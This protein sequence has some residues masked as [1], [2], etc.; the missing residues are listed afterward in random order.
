MI[1]T[2]TKII[3]LLSLGLL[4]LSLAVYAGFVFLLS[5]HKGALYSEQATVLS[6]AMQKKSLEDL[7]KTVEQS[8][9]ERETLR[10]YVLEDDRVIDLLSLIE[11]VAAEQGATLTTSALAV[12]PIDDTFETLALTVSVTGSF[13]NMMRV[14]AMIETLPQQSVISSVLF[15]KTEKEGGGEWQGTI[16]LKV[17][18]FKRI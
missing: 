13:S 14:L 5:K 3:A 4:V 7:V 1:H 15:T 16:D 2:R 12:V 18:K 6:V 11:T 8:K 17:T 9:N 10:G